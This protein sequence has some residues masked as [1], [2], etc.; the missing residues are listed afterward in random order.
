MKKG[1]I[2]KPARTY[3]DW[4]ALSDQDWPTGWS[5]FSRVWPESAR[6]T[7]Y[8]TSVTATVRLRRPLQPEG[9]TRKGTAETYQIDQTLNN[10]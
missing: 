7:K 6:P 10:W 9:V 8:R 4:N 5:D 1:V 3:W 2:P